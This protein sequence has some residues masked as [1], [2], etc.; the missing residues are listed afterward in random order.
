[1]QS[2]NIKALKT[3]LNSDYTIEYF[4]ENTNKPI[5]YSFIHLKSLED[6]FI[7]E[8]KNNQLTKYI[9]YLNSTLKIPQFD[10]LYF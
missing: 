9:N 2:K 10:I 5:I 4:V 8:F 3:F 1:M 7:H 6:T